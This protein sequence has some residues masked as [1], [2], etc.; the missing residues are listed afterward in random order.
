MNGSLCLCQW[1]VITVEP[2][3]STRKRAWSTANQKITLVRIYLAWKW[4]KCQVLKSRKSSDFFCDGSVWQLISVMWESILGWQWVICCS[5][6][7]DKHSFSFQCSHSA[8]GYSTE[9]SKSDSQRGSVRDGRRC[10]LNFLYHYSNNCPVLSAL[11]LFV[12]S[13]WWQVPVLGHLSLAEHSSWVQR[14]AVFN[15]LDSVCFHYSEQRQY[16]EICCINQ[17]STAQQLAFR[18]QKANCTTVQYHRTWTV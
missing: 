1:A 17:G 13:F 15:Q 7:I 11:Q 4:I 9:T 18:R 2:M 10:N 5:T 3:G 14:A 16:N 6:H 8:H 12:A